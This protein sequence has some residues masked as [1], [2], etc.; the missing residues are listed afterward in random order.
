MAVGIED[1]DYY[2]Q[3]RAHMAK[4][5]PGSGSVPSPESAKAPESR[6]VRNVL[7]GVAVGLA[8]MAGAHAL[9]GRE[10]A[11]PSALR[12]EPIPRVDPVATA[13]IPLQVSPSP[14]PLRRDTDFASRE[15]FTFL[16]MFGSSVK[17]MSPP[18]IAPSMSKPF[19]V[20]Y[21]D[22][23]VVVEG[24]WTHDVEVIFTP[25]FKERLFAIDRNS[26]IVNLDKDTISVDGLFI[27]NVLR[28]DTTAGPET[29]IGWK[30]AEIN[31]AAPYRPLSQIPCPQY[32]WDK[33]DI[34][35]G[36][37]PYQGPTPPLYQSDGRGGA[38]LVRPASPDWKP[39]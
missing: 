4:G 19:V 2:R 35:R 7:I 38:Y 12:I 16:S 34:C 29:G 37:P 28:Y 30:V 17:T 25:E 36:R 14:V 39:E 26:E 13:A 21:T 5:D 27:V 1:R 8:I 20:N 32:D 9:R 18:M 11:K 10:D 31:V 33:R 15:W 22:K 24:D 23:R 6:W 3:E